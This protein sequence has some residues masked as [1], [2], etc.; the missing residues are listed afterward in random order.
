MNTSERVGTPGS[1]K[2]SRKGTSQTEFLRQHRVPEHERHREEDA[3]TS[4]ET[5]IYENCILFGIH[6]DGLPISAD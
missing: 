1:I 6:F 2:I 4:S 3:L 5:W